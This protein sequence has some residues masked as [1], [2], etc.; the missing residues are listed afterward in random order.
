MGEVRAIVSRIM[1]ARVESGIAVKQ[2]LGN[3]DITTPTGKISKELQAVILD[4]TNIKKCSV[5]KGELMVNVDL[6]LTP[7]LVREGIAREV[8][9]KVN[10]LRKDAGMTIADRIHLF[11]WSDSAEVMKMY[12][13]FSEDLKNDTL[14]SKVEFGKKEGLANVASFRVAEQDLSIGF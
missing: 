8:T 4:E 1:E 5:K 9:R 3:V 7:E 2:A 14:A 6:K 10:G 11:I 12:E 13:E